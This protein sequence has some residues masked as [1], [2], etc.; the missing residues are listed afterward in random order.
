MIKIGDKVLCD[1]GYK[2]TVKAFL[3]N[4]TVYVDVLD[5]I[6]KNKKPQQVIR[7]HMYN[8]NHIK[9]IEWLNLKGSESYS[10]FY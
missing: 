4:D 1:Y 8:V 3:S 10:F 6:Y 7:R 9:R 2:G 5:T